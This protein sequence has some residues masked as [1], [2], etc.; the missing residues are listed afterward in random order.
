[1]DRDNTTQSATRVDGTAKV[2]LRSTARVLQFLVR[3]AD[4]D[5]AGPRQKPAHSGRRAQAASVRAVLLVFWATF[6][7]ACIFVAQPLTISGQYHAISR[8]QYNVAAKHLV[9]NRARQS[10]NENRF[11]ITVENSDAGI[12]ASA[13]TTDTIPCASYSGWCTSSTGWQFTLAPNGTAI[14]AVSRAVSGPVASTGIS[15]SLLPPA[16]QFILGQTADRLLS[17]IIRDDGTVDPRPR[18]HGLVLPPYPSG[19]ACYN[20]SEC[21]SG[22]TCLMM[23]C[24][25]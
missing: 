8:G 18:P 6:N 11:P 13:V 12:L 22:L 2:L 14:L 21:E 9:W 25:R 23:H 17:S 19:A 15:D 20:T 10:F 1:M 7:S 5:G 4:G 3:T 24:T 16:S